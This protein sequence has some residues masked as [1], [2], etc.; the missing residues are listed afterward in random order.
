M[1]EKLL[2]AYKLRIIKHNRTEEYV[3]I[4]VN[5]LML[6]AEIKN[7]SIDYYIFNI[8]EI[9]IVQIFVSE[10]AKSYTHIFIH[11]Y[12]FFFNIYYSVDFKEFYL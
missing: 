5:N 1:L 3:R 8:Q 6:N 11:V 9:M 2:I 4:N 7:I 12:F 10:C